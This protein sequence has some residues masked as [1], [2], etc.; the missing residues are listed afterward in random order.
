MEGVMAPLDEHKE[1]IGDGAYPALCNGI[2]VAREDE[3]ELYRVTYVWL[4]PYVDSDGDASILSETRTVIV[5]A[6][7][8]SEFGDMSA[9][10]LY[11][12]RV[13]DTWIKK[14]KPLLLTKDRYSTN[15]AAIVTSIDPFRKQHRKT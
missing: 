5:L 15:V 13:H 12:G 10:W 1:A 3:E 4:C 6:T 2:R 7:L 14:P 11:R 8:S 9:Q